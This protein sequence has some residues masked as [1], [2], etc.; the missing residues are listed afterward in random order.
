MV[1]NTLA[2]FFCG[3]SVGLPSLEQKKIAEIFATSFY[4]I[5]LICFVETCQHILIL[6]LLNSYLLFIGKSSVSAHYVAVWRCSK[7]STKIII[8]IIITIIIGHRQE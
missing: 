6:I 8:V 1:K 7:G 2:L 4:F 3:Y 5:K